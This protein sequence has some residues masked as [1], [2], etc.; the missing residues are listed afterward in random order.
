MG[1][2]LLPEN[3]DLPARTFK[4]WTL[5]KLDYLQRYID[6]FEVSMRDKPWCARCYIDL[7][8]GTGKCQIEG[9]NEFQL[10]SSLIAVT[11][12]FPFTH[13]FFVDK[14][15][16][17]I[18]ALSKRCETMSKQS[19][20][21][22]VGDANYIVQQIADEI[23]DIDKNRSKDQWP[24]LNLAFLDPDGLELEWKTVKSLASVKK[25]DLII[26]YSQSGLTRNFKNYIN[27]DEETLIDKF[28]GGRNW[29]KIYKSTLE[30]E[31][32][33]IH[34]RLLD[35]YKQNLVNL[36]YVDVKDI[37]DNTEPLMKNSKHAPL[38]RLIFASKH[39]RGHDFWNK[40]IKKDMYGQSKLF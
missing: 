23:N 38:Y 40:V 29:R 15:Q 25:M 36:G 9:H 6:L 18:E 31:P 24:S 8:A 14:S 2:Y 10:G 39:K 12:K 13:Y 17:N 28:F 21:F 30:K 35:H 20:K 27:S 34:R 33:G 16:D 3:D 19:M 5:E 26:H 11:T 4:K 1:S 32:S 37:G 7:F 22:I